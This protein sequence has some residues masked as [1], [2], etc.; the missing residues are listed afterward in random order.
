MRIHSDWLRLVHL[1]TA[2]VYANNVLP[3]YGSIYLDHVEVG[4]SKS[5]KG[6]IEF[7]LTGDGTKSKRLT[8]T[9]NAGAG[10]EYA[11]TYDQW[12]YTLAFLFDVDPRATVSTGYKY[13]GFDDYHRQTKGKYLLTD[14]LTTRAVLLDQWERMQA[15]VAGSPSLRNADIYI[16]RVPQRILHEEGY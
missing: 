9:G 12:G 3:E 8:N 2:I 13:A 1:T 10:D 4:G 16:P 15:I 14:D 11:A 5:R 7:R 6:A